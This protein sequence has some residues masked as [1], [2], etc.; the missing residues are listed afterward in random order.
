M[1]PRFVP[2]RDLGRASRKQQT[3]GFN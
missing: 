1:R 3:D 2:K